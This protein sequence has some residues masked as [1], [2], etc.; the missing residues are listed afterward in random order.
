MQIHWPCVSSVRG[1]VA[2]V[3]NYRAAFDAAFTHCSHIGCPWRRAS[4][5]ERYPQ[6]T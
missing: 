2:M 3:S 4:D 6:T 1:R 5:A